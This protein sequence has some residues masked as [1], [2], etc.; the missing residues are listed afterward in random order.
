M[1]RA[2]LIGLF[3]FALLSLFNAGSADAALG[4]GL[5]EK[6]RNEASEV[7][8]V[9]IISSKKGE[10]KAERRA[11]IFT[12]EVIDVT[13]SAAKHKPGD[14]VTIHSYVHR[15]FH[16]GSYQ[17]G[18]QAPK[19]LPDGWT[20]VAYLKPV[21]GGKDLRIAAYGHSFVEKKTDEVKDAN[22]ERN[23]EKAGD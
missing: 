6:M 11:V 22:E 18:P 12:A 7:L 16:P 1:F 19:L 23:Q 15:K 9:R 10:S 17:P 14:V 13:R 5:I 8:T 3:A 21:K 20:G 4:P 2:S